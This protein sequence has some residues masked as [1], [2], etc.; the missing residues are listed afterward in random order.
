MSD[1]IIYRPG[2]SA[3]Q[4]GRAR[5]KSW[6]LEFA[7][8]DAKRPDALMGWAGSSDTLS[9]V[10][11]RFPGLDEA[12]AYAEKAG[13]S[14]HVRSDRARRVRPRSYADNFR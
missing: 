9:Q 14:Y 5:T 6:V 2:K 7:P 12:R 1:A 10:R 8:G 13:L 3:M 4:S 11:L